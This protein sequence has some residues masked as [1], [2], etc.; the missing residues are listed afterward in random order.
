MLL[1]DALARAAQ[2]RPDDNAVVFGDR[3]L[4]WSQWHERVRRLTGALASAGIGR[5]DRVA[6][7]DRNHVAVLDAILAAGALGAATV[8]PNWRLK[9]EDGPAKRAQA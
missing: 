5:G 6:V 4:T 7:L 1:S 9:D 3:L 8:V 2:E